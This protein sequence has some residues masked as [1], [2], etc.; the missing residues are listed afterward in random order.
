MSV[1]SYPVII[2]LY[3]PLIGKCGY[4]RMLKRVSS[5]PMILLLPAISFK[6]NSATHIVIF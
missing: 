1:E 6:A 5:P 2:W 3:T 4:C